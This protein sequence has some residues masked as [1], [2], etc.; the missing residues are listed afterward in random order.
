MVFACF[1]RKWRFSF[2]SLTNR[3]SVEYL[4][5][6]QS[7]PVLNVF[8]AWDHLNS[9]V[10]EPVFI[11]G[12][13]LKK[14]VSCENN[15]SMR[16]RST[17]VHNMETWQ[18]SWQGIFFLMMLRGGFLFTY[19]IRMRKLTKVVRKVNFSERK[20]E[21]MHQL[22][23]AK[24]CKVYPGKRLIW[25]YHLQLSFVYKAESQISFNF[26]CSGDKRLLSEFLRKWGWFQG[27]NE[28]FP[29]YLG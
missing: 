13:I 11:S 24:R 2:L 27:Q 3:C 25:H 22:W 9:I 1:P 4:N 8:I 10:N 5:I 20:F 21:D 28:C 26:F 17:N 18:T 19:F 7:I 6:L 15:L 12:K 16:N 23:R 29:K 14:T